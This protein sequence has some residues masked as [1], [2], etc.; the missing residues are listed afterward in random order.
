MTRRTIPPELR[1]EQSRQRYVG[2]DALLANFVAATWES[3]G[4]KV[5]ANIYREIRNRKLAE[6]GSIPPPKDT[7]I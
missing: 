2:I 4:D 6:L 3:R 7:I 5:R 1:R